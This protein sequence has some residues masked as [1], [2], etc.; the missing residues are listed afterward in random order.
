MR[1][2]RVSL[3]TA[4]GATAL[5]VGLAALGVMASAAFGVATAREVLAEGPWGG[6]RWGGP[7]WSG[8]V[9]SAALPPGIAELAD[10]PP[11]ERFQHFQG[12]QVDLTDRDGNPVAI[13]GTPGKVSAASTM[14]L[15]LALNEGS[16]RTFTLDDK[17]VVRRRPGPGGSRATL[18]SISKDDRVVV[19][20]ASNSPTALAVIVGSSD[21][22]GPPFRRGARP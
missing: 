11:N 21:G 16:T 15:T 2:F 4:L 1:R 12:F 7:P 9:W 18:A 10:L 22:S 17:T 13:I 20:T 5:V 14:S 6:S 8:E 3:R 19:M